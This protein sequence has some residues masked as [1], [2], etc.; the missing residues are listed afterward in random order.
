VLAALAAAAVLLALAQG[1]ALGRVVTEVM[2]VVVRAAETTR[3]RGRLYRRSRA[4]DHAAAALRAGTAA[5]LARALGLA[6]SAGAD[7]LLDALTRATGHPAER[8]RPLLYGPPPTDDAGL[9][10]LSA[11]L[12]TLESEVHRS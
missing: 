2:P 5:R 11:A 1:R 10:A 4:H 8:L 6:H 12:D 9:L 3:G 7:T